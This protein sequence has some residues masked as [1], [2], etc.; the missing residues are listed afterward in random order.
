MTPNRYCIACDAGLA[1]VP[2]G[3]LWEPRPRLWH[4]WAI[5]L[6]WRYS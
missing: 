3:T 4:Q 5:A 2:I 6:G 1:A